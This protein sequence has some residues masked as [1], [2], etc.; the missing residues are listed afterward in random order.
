MKHR[1]LLSMLLALVMVLSL[2]PTAVFADGNGS[3][4]PAATTHDGKVYVVGTEDEELNENDPALYD[5]GTYTRADMDSADEYLTKQFDWTDK[6]AGEGVI[7][8]KMK[9]NENKESTGTALYVFTTCCGHGFS[10]EIAQK[11]LEFLLEHYERVDVVVVTGTRAMPGSRLYSYLTGYADIHIVEDVGT[12]Y[13][14]LLNG[15]YT[16]SDWNGWK[17]ITS[18]NW[19]YLGGH[20]SRSIYTALYAYLAGMNN[21]MA[22]ASNPTETL[23]ET[24]LVRKPDAIYVSFD[25]FLGHGIETA[26]DANLVAPYGVPYSL[27]FSSWNA[28]NIYNGCITYPDIN[29]DCWNIL[30]DYDVNG[31]YHSFGSF[32]GEPAS[33]DGWTADDSG[34]P[35]FVFYYENRNRNSTLGL[36]DAINTLDTGLHYRMWNELLALA[37]PSLLAKMKDNADDPITIGGIPTD[38]L[39]NGE[40][41]TVYNAEDGSGY[42]SKLGGWIS[43]DGYDYGYYRIKDTP[44]L[45]D[46]SQ[47][48]DFDAVNQSADNSP[49]SIVLKD[50]FSSYFSR[51][52]T[53]GA[54]EWQAEPADGAQVNIIQTSGSVTFAAV[55]YQAGTEITFRIPVRC[56]SNTTGKFQWVDTNQSASLTVDRDNGTT[57]TYDITSP[58]AHLEKYKISITKYWR[59]PTDDRTPVT[60]HLLA[61]GVEVKSDTYNPSSSGSAVR[62]YSLPMYRDGKKIEYT[63]VEDPNEAYLTEYSKS[64]NG[65]SLNFTV[66]NYTKTTYHVEKV[67]D[68][69]DD[70]DGIRPE[71][72]TVVLWRG[73]DY[74]NLDEKV[75]E[76]VVTPNEE[77]K[78]EYTFTDLPKYSNNNKP[79][80]YGA[81]EEAVDGYKR[82][83]DRYGGN[84]TVITNK[85]TPVK[86]YFAAEKVWND[87]KNLDGM[88]PEEITITLLADGNPVQSVHPTYFQY[89]GEGIPDNVWRAFFSPVPKYNKDGTEIEYTAVE[90]SVSGYRSEL[91]IEQ[92]WYGSTTL[93]QS[94]AFIFTNTQMVTIRG[95]KTWDDIDNRD[96]LRPDSITINLM[97]GDAM[98]ETKTVTADDGWAWSFTVP[99]YDKDGAEIN[100]TIEEKPVTGY[101]ATVSGYNVTNTRDLGTLKIVK[102]ATGAQVPAGTTFTITGT[103]VAKDVTFETV[104]VTYADF[105]DG[106][107]TLENV[108]TGD[109]TVTEAV[110]G[111]AVDGYTLTVSGNGAE[112]QIDK[113]ETVEFAIEN[114]YELDLG[115]L[116]IVKTATGAQTPD[117]TRFTITGTPVAKDVTFETRTV[118][119]ADFE[120]GV[121]TLE[122]PTGTYTVTENTDDATLAGYKLTVTGDNGA[123]KT[124]EKNGTVKF[125]ILNKYE[126]T[127]SIPDNPTP[128]PTPE[129]NTKD[130]YAY[131]IG[132]PDGE[133]KP[134][135]TI[136]RAETVTIFFRMLTDESRDAIWSTENSFTDVQLTEWFN[137]A[138][139]TMENG[140][141][142]NGYP[143]G[144]FH[145]NGNIT[146]AEFAAMA[147]RFFQD[148]KVGPSKFSD[149]IGHW[150]AEAIS[151]AQNEG[152]IMGYPDGTFHPDQPI[153]RAEAMTIFNRVLK[154]APHKDHLVA[155][156]IQW[157]DNMNKAVWY[158]ADVQ[159]AT[160]SH[161]YTMSDTTTSAHEI[162]QKLLPV[163]DWE[164][165]EK[166][167]STAHSASNPGEVVN[168]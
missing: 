50:T 28:N 120:N 98:V 65:A 88:R 133:V 58:K 156:M 60:I 30:Y 54:I 104:T 160:N 86:V 163:R 157:P 4:D 113:G 47:G 143:D 102:T 89:A 125:T 97:N 137:N 106:V 135:G 162:W 138:I 72:I 124:L 91:S 139:S 57:N 68:D 93:T 123:T 154:R 82:T 129:L 8:L 148:A 7:T 29:Y 53:A 118:R 22:L 83:Y 152:L 17:G 51:F 127:P 158:Y 116:K 46:Y 87:G 61:D 49:K 117:G 140:G 78:W 136:T 147:I 20:F 71:S 45:F 64:E 9:L 12:N 76:Q 5:S 66:T 130:H 103:P 1:K 62:E 26:S 128:P 146:R 19:T 6:D 105:T 159:E 101:T 153:T 59:M 39:W 131:I 3:D 132:Y 85:H 151:K 32:A 114:A 109:Y 122:I 77:G 38:H 112:Q 150:A 42:L 10:K 35:E 40:T 145:P 56:N 108:P 25:G 75:T 121:Y 48:D 84:K 37:D 142:I 74:R 166:A 33:A 161:T 63:V 18:K 41:R 119:Y 99:K 44:Y 164:A 21:A 168:N 34:K 79:Y 155:N 134:N 13:L 24:E 31:K 14:A 16:G 110:D 27:N 11:N 165:F 70:E 141:I 111:A 67:W 36:E 15:T 167:W 96:G 81:S 107:Y 2:A 43:F 80:Y 92:K 94:T 23:T 115:T 55:A 52:S 100:Y 73:E 90:E 69:N 126:R 144:S 149:T 95:A